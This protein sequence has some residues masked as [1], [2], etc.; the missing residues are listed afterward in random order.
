[1]KTMKKTFRLFSM[2]AVAL[3]MAACSSEDIMTQQQPA[4]QDGKLHFT[5]TIAAPSADNMRTVYTEVTEGTDAG[6]IK[7]AWKVGDEIAVMSS[8]LQKRAAV[9]V[10]TVNNDGSATVEGD[11][12]GV[13]DNGA[14]ILL[15]YPASSLG[16]SYEGNVEEQD[17]TLGFIAENL[18]IRGGQG[19]LK[20][21]G[22]KAT[23]EDDV[24]MQSQIAIWKL[25]LQNND[26]TPA[27]LSATK[28]TIK[29]DTEIKASTKTL[30]TATST[31]YLAVPSID[32]KDITIEATVGSD[33]Y[34]Y[35]KAGGTLEAGKYY[36][37]TVTMELDGQATP[38]T[39]EAITA[40]TIKVWNPKSGMKYSKNGGEK[41]TMSSETSSTE[42]SVAAGDKV[43]FYCNGFNDINYTFFA[44]TAEVKVYG[45]IMSLVNESS[46]ATATEL[47]GRNFNGLFANY[48]VLKDASGLLL[49]ATTLAN[50]CYQNLFSSCTS[51]TT[52]PKL[53][54]TSLAESC[55]SS[56][57]SG[58]TSLATAPELKA[59]S[60]AK[61]CYSYMFY[62]CTSL[63]T[64]YVKAA[65]ENG[66]RECEEMFGGCT[67][68]GAV[69]HTTTANKNGWSS[70]IP[71]NWT[72]NDDWN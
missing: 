17:G 38:L 56:M 29:A 69:L 46:F 27:A 21:D 42:I 6:T 45:N 33:T 4:Q 44:G 60:L 3:M 63:T 23:L 10:K 5:A 65:Y 53:K 62:G 8:D 20:V 59:T 40:G 13:G 7:V 22:D 16:G 71:S 51:L 39:L 52:A 2:A 57:F 43:A 58:C 24:K 41:I 25:A 28:V 36:Q 37:S 48:D 11:I 19:T 9:T 72:V 1:M 14:N 12:S 34:S 30:T 54:A 68:P 18:D 50:G 70:A 31:V 66:D 61:S 67:A 35:S 55:Y 49:P 64:A 15:I 32:N 26:A 47:T